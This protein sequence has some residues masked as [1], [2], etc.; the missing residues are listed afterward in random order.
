[1]L[2]YEK[3]NCQNYHSFEA[4]TYLQSVHELLKDI[5]FSF[6]DFNQPR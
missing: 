3:C 6:K 5:V 2:Q 1:M 4:S